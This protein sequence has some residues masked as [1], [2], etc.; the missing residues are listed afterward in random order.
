MDFHG[1]NIYKIFREKK[2]KN[3]LDYSSN[4]NPFGISENLKKTILENFESIEKYPDPDYFKL[5]KRISE[6]IKVDLGNIILGNGATEII[7]LIIKVLNLKKV[8]IVSPTFGEYERAVKSLQNSVKINYFKLDEEENFKFNQK[9]FE[10]E[11]E[12]NYDLVIICNPNNPTGKFLKKDEMEKILEKCNQKGAKL[13]V[14]EAF[15]EFIQNWKKETI[16]QT[17]INKKNLFVIRAFTK[18]FAIP[19]LRLGYGIGFDKEIIC[20]MNEKKEPWSVNSLAEIAGICALDDLDYIKKTEDWIKE[21]KIYMFKKLSEIK[22]IEVF[23]TEVNFILV[24]IKKE[25]FEKGM[26]SKKL[27]EEMLKHGILIRDASNFIFL[28]KKYFRLAIKDRKNNDFVLKILKE[29]LSQENQ[30]Y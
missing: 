15:I 28:G 17:K 16:I 29:I 18:F 13:L 30:T 14:D 3:I 8:L 6:K 19:G 7:F 11:M 20:K 5:K 22:E 26:D 25:I 27:Q 2:I 24:K 23:K 12:K 4:I 21:E 1:G 9:K 10:N